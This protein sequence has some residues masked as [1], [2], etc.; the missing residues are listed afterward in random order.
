MCNAQP[1]QLV[2]PG[3]LERV[4]RA[5]DRVA[6]PGKKGIEGQWELGGFG[7]SVAFGREDLRA[8]YSCL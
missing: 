5:G 2:Q 3:Q 7:T 6:Q 8:H 4:A 1:G